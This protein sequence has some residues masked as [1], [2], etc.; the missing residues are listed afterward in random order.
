MTDTSR[1][2]SRL[3]EFGT[4][5]FTVV[6]ALSN[7]HG[8]VNLGQGFPDFDGPEPIRRAAAEAVMSGPNQYAPLAG[9]GRLRH[10][11]ADWMS[12]SRSVDVDAEREVT[13]TAGATGGLSAVMLGLL[14]PGDEVVLV[15]PWYDAYPAAVVMAGGRPTYAAPE[16]P[17]Y[18]I[19]AATLEA[20]VTPATRALVINSPHNPTGRVLD[21][22]EWDAIERVV[23]EHDLVLVSDEVYESLVYEGSHRSPIGRPALRDRCIVVSSIGKTF[24]LTGWK[25][26]WT[27]A[28]P[29]LTE[30]VRASHQFTIFSVAT[31]L[32]VGAEAALGMPDAYFEEFVDSY[33]VRRDLL[34]DGLAAA[35]LRPSTPQGT[36][37]ALADVSSLGV[38]DD[39]AFCERMIRELGVAAIPT[40]PFHHDRRSGPIRFAFCKSEDV[41]RTALDRLQNVGSIL[42]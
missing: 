19:D 14:E 32:Q 8:A 1:T 42:P 37:F 20:A 33:R 35:G 5:I 34:V 40:S 7:R 38:D 39:L 27:V 30:A 18:R 16:A 6:S 9:T 12:R 11:I 15:E 10:A 26:G 29:A 31:P 17:G 13:V 36:Y 2:A 22:A 25:V 41:I 4:S 24:S 3:R 21:E 23:L 28:A